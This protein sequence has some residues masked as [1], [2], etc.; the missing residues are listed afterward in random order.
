MAMSHEG[1]AIPDA[2]EED[3]LEQQLPAEPD[4]AEDSGEPETQPDADP[5]FPAGSEADRLEQ[6]RDGGAADGEDDYPRGTGEEYPE[7]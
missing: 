7:D 3:T 6:A 5:L 2:N 4:P 1:P